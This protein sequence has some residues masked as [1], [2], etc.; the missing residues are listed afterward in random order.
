MPATLQLAEWDALMK[1][2][3]RLVEEE[4][5][6]I[7]RRAVTEVGVQV[8][9][10]ARN[11]MPPEVRQRGVAK[12]W[13]P[14]Q[15]R[16]WWATMHK[17][18]SGE[19]RALPGWKAVYRVVNGVKRLEISGAYRRTG[20]LVKSLTYQVDQPSASQTLLRYG[21]NRTYAPYVI[22]E[23]RQSRYHEGNWP[24]LQGIVRDHLPKL[25]KTFAD[26]VF[27]EVNKVI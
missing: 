27:E 16:W 11:D 4:Q 14:R 2:I 26:K 18:A 7:L 6:I 8:D 24:T 10:I 13:T 17:K 19:S 5:K 3:R 15:R 20:T 23:K 9:E 25:Q 1:D 22:D 12:Y 21:T